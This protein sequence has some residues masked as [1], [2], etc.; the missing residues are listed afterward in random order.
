MFSTGQWIFAAVFVVVFT[1][2]IIL[3]YK[4]DRNLHRK[5]YKGVI[6]VGLVFIT[7]IILLFIIKQLLR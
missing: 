1:I 4:K 5:N 6:W 3:S 7:F 2:F